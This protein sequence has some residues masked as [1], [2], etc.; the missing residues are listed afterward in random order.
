MA[1]SPG[2]VGGLDKT[3]VAVPDQ[4]ATLDGATLSGQIG[5]LPPDLVA[6]PE[7]KAAL[8]L[9]RLKPVGCQQDRMWLPRKRVS[10][11][12]SAL[13]LGSGIP[14]GVLARSL[15]VVQSRSI[16]SSPRTGDRFPAAQSKGDRG[17]SITE[18]TTQ[19]AVVQ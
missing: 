9:D 13:A 2:G 18:S 16:C 8:V 6:G 17:R 12:L 4:L 3:G 15:C 5:R 19:R 7:L 11:N 14:F 1:E 10:N